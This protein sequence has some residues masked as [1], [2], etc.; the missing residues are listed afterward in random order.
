[1]RLLE[2]LSKMNILNQAHALSFFHKKLNGLTFSCLFFDDNYI[3]Q[4]RLQHNTDYVVV[5]IQY[6]QPWLQ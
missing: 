5:D 4:P 3:V 1:M 6:E 2:K